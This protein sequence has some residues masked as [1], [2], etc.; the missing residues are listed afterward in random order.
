MIRSVFIG[1]TSPAAI[2][3]R[4]ASPEA[5]TTSYCPVRISWTAS[6]EVPKVLMVTLQPD[7]FSKSETQSTAGSLLPSS[8]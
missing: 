5:E 6:S 4:V 8:T 3:R 7:S 1:S 2:I